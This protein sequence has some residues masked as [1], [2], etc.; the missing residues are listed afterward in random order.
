MVGYGTK[1]MMQKSCYRKARLKRYV[2]KCRLKL[3]TEPASLTSSGKA[4]HSYAP[5]H[6]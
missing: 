1:E 3:S 2:Y 4:F 5:K 6:N